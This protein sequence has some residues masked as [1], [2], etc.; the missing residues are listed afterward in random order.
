M[1]ELL[2]RWGQ[3]Y[4]TLLKERHI[5]AGQKATGKSL[6]EFGYEATSLKLDVFGGD[7]TEY[8]ERGRGGGGFPPVNN[9][10]EWA[11]ARGMFVNIEKE[12]KKRGIAYI[13]ARSIAEKG[14]Y[15]FRTGKTYAGMKNP[16]S[17]VFTQELEDEM[18]A[19]IMEETTNQIQ[20][21]I[22]KT[23]KDYVKSN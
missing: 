9:I 14:S 13:I 18:M 23:Y 7:N 21:L 20:A 8:L 19:D 16:I 1:L 12:Y 17:G 4:V 6:S 5:E 2:Q 3:I 15:L 10:Y 22:T 11:E